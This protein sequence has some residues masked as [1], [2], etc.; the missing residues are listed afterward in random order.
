M[1]GVSPTP[2]EHWRTLAEEQRRWAVYL[3]SRGEYP[4]VAHN[5]AALYDAAATSLD[6]E[7]QHGEPFCV[8]HL[9]PMRAMREQDAQRRRS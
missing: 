1:P 4:G 9:E 3:A 2:Q 5:K 6:L 7:A 8:C